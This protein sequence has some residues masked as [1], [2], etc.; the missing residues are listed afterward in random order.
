M[1][2]FRLASLFFVVGMSHKQK[3]PQL[4][5]EWKALGPT[6]FCRAT[7]PPRATFLLWS[8]LRSLPR[9][10]YWLV[11]VKQQNG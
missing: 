2:P 8:P 5:M 11:V 4:S 1:R 10:A 9:L 7:S 3:R 6:Q